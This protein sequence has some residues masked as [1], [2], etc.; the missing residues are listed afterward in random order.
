MRKKILD[1]KILY[2]VVSVLLAIV[3]WFYVTS[4]DGNESTKT[5]KNIPVTFTGVDVLEERNLMIVG[6]IPTATVEVRAT[7][8]VLAK[9]TDSTVS[10]V[11]N[12]SQIT[13]ASEYRLAYTATLP[14]G[15]SQNDV[16]FVSG[17][18]G[19]VTFTVA[20]FVTREVD[21]RG[22]F[23]GT[24]AE[25]YLP[26][27]SDEFIFAPKKLTI[28]GQAGMVNQVDHVLV[29][30][31][32]EGL[33]HDVSGEFSYQLIGV[34]GEP[35]EDLDV[36]CSE[37]SIYVTY[38]IWATAEIELDLKFI[39]GGGVSED[40]VRYTMTNDRITV[41]GTKDAV[42]AITDGSITLATINL[43]TVNDGDELTFAVPLA[44]ELRNIS[45]ITEVTIKFTLPHLVTKTL[46]A[47]D[48]SCINLPDGWKAQLVT[49]VLPVEV[50]GSAAMLSDVS[51][52][53]IR[54]V[55]DMK[56]VN[57]VAGQHTVPVKIYLDSVGSAGEVGVIGSEH[58]V[59]VALSKK[60]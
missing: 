54:V 12:V 51:E 13:E 49:Q 40:T 57:L 33:D 24:A 14:S 10:L 32:G 15:V 44:D 56:D 55:A 38:P 7:P 50:R 34:S 19:N 37:E 22:Q 21:I 5:I 47:T 58:K 60:K 4:L 52:D 26:G 8:T 29:S 18:T 9:L 42:A 53:S 28:S 1:S 45:G 48:I 23:V 20:R 35:L 43:A 2:M 6:S 41:A 59:V 46:Y 25:G 11:V 30:V 17:Y 36:T 31:G 16:E 39:P 27:G 3:L